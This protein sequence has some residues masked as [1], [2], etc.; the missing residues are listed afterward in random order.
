MPG[1]VQALL[2]AAHRHAP[3]PDRGHRAPFRGV[4]QALRQGRRRRPLRLRPE[5]G[6]RRAST[7]S[8]GTLRSAWSRASRRRSRRSTRRSSASATAPTASARSRASRSRRSA[9]SPSRSPGTRP[10]PRSRSRTTAT[11]PAPR[12]A[13]SASWARRAARSW[14]RTPAATNR[15]AVRG[16]P[17]HLAPSARRALEYSLAAAMAAA[18]LAGG[19]A[20]KG[21]IA[22]RLPFGTYGEARAASRSSPASSTWSTWATPARRG[23]SSPGAAS[24]SPPWP[25]RPCSHLLWR[26]AL[27]LRE[28]AAQVGFG[29]LCGGIA[30]KPDRP[31]AARPRDRL[32][33]LPLRQPT[34]IRRSTWPTPAICVG[35][36][37][38][39]LP[40]AAAPGPACAGSRRSLHVGDLLAHALELVLQLDH[41]AGDGQVVRLAP[42]GVRLAAHLLQDE[43]RLAADLPVRP[44]QRGQLLEMAAEARD[45]LGDVAAVGVK[46]DFLRTRS[47]SRSSSR[48]AS[49]SRLSSSSR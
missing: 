42:E 2:Q 12:R 23:A 34:S 10:R 1:E 11:A 3:P 36:A 30:G 43:F 25:R 13:S 47:S 14:R 29:L 49:R 28:P 4:A 33:R 46:G 40:L 32:P 31:A 21:W 44:Q 45:L 19:P 37:L 39:L 8:T 17:V 7:P 15:P 24:S 48:P 41:A 9:C 35:V 6:R 5:H 26:Q 16:R 22:G 27:G 18:V 20:Q 38:Y